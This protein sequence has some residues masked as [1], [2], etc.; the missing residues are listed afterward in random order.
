[1]PDGSPAG[2]RVFFDTNILLYLFDR[3]SEEKRRITVELFNKHHQSG[4]LQLSLQVVHEFAANLLKK[5]RMPQ[6]TVADLVRDLLALD[7]AALRGEDTLTALQFMDNFRVS[8]WDALILATAI[9]EGC[10]I[11]YSEDF[12]DGRA[13]GPLKVIN[14]FQ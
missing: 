1:M 8:F 7:V 13:Y 11:L 3:S 2:T 4:S 12:Q 9:R 5:F 6:S 10:K 14:P